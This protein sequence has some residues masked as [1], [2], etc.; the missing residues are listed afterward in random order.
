MASIPGSVTL[1]GFIAPTDTDDVYATHDEIYGR[2]GYRTVTDTTQR[3]NIP[4]PRRKEGM[5]VYVTQTDT[6]YKLDADLLTWSN[7]STGT[8]GTTGNLTTGAGLTGADVPVNMSQ[9]ITVALDVSDLTAGALL[10]ESTDYVPMYDSSLG[11]TIKIKVLDIAD[12]G[13]F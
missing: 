2:G 4:A 8:G 7:F 5:L 11:Q 3:D 12:G 10:S 9:D 6:V 1:G 13:T